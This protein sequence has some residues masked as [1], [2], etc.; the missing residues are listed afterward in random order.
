M[1]SGMRNVNYE[2]QTEAIPAFLSVALTI[3]TFNVANG[4]AAA[5]IVYVILKVA[6]GRKREIPKAM[7]PF[8]LLLCYYFYTLTI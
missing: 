4:I 1:L 2:D 7:Y 5:I 6:S 8:A 3:F